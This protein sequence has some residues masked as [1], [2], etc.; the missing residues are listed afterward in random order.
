MNKKLKWCLQIIVAIIG[1]ISIYFVLKP[2]RASQYLKKGQE[3]IEQKKIDEALE[4]LEKAEKLDPVNPRIHYHLGQIFG[5][6]GY[7]EIGDKTGKLPLQAKYYLKKSLEEFLEAERTLHDIQIQYNLG[8][9]HELLGNFQQAFDSF[10]RA[11]K[12]NPTYEN[13]AEKLSESS[14]KL[15]KEENLDY[16]V[17]I[18]PENYSAYLKLG[19]LYFS[20]HR[21][22]QAKE[23]YL[24]IRGNCNWNMVLQHID[25]GNFES[26]G[27]R[28]D[29][30]V[31]F[32]LTIEQGRFDVS[33]DLFKKYLKSSGINLLLPYIQNNETSAQKM[34]LI[35]TTW[36]DVIP[37]DFHEFLCCLNMSQ[38][39][40]FLEEFGY[41]TYFPQQEIGSTG[42][43]VPG[44]I[45]VE[46]S[47]ERGNYFSSIRINGLELSYNGRGFNGAIVDVETGKLKIRGTFD[48]YRNPEEAVK[49]NGFIENAEDGDIVILS[50]KDEGARMLRESIKTTFRTIGAHPLIDRSKMHN[51]YILIGVK[52]AEPG[53]SV[54]FISKNPIKRSVLM[55]SKIKNPQEYLLK[56]NIDK[57]AIYISGLKQDSKVFFKSPLL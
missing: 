49:L 14:E 50:V 57:H 30:I 34:E 1:I 26:E 37:I 53:T 11:Y 13:I 20:S 16:A 25:K 3:F 17:K 12:Y 4:V 47:T 22:Y 44:D 19:R 42:I 23:N 35:G 5:L 27:R 9:T 10:D 21:Y 46:S 36:K 28:Y 24:K 8:V 55:G 45:V 39:V 54:E 48:T 33:F 52:G 56:E 7:F 2:Y 41:S 6:K 29:E 18:N 38:M 43:K 40:D 31:Y 51:S 32:L 15:G